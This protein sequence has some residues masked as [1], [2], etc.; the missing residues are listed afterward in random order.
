[1]KPTILS[2]S[3]AAGLALGAG[4]TALAQGQVDPADQARYNQQLQDYQNQQSQYQAQQQSYQD[5][6]QRYRDSRNA[7]A[8]RREAWQDQR[9]RWA[10]N[11][12]EYL[13][14]RDLYD[15]HHGPGAWDRVYVWDHGYVYRRVY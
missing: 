6:Q 8:A 7:Y 4:T 1:M 11:R 10:A 15:Y 3:L 2:L 9:E 14:Q 5:Q 13:R 12:D